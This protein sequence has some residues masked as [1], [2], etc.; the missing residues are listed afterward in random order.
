[1]KLIDST[2]Q[3]PLAVDITDVPHFSTCQSRALVLGRP[4]E[5][6]LPAF[7]AC[8]PRRDSHRFCSQPGNSTLTRG[9]IT[10]SGCS[11]RIS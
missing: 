9:S 4:L 6:R 7:H 10:Y 3:A 11:Q 2:A 5:T 1:M 8:W